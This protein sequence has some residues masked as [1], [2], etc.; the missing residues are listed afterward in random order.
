MVVH[1]EWWNDSNGQVM[2]GDLLK[3]AL[4]EKLNGSLS[5]CTQGTLEDSVDRDR[6]RKVVEAAKVL[7]EP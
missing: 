1:A 7:R 6:W 3:K 4:V 2:S 5:K